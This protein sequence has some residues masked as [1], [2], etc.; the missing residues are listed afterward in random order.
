MQ[1]Q[2]IVF[3]FTLINKHKKSCSKN[4]LEQLFYYKLW[5]T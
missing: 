2:A 4:I 3:V 1:L 5:S